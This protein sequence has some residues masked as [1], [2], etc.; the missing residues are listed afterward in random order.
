MEKDISRKDK[1]SKPRQRAE[2]ILDAAPGEAAKTHS[3]EEI[4]ALIHEMD[5]HKIELEMQNDEL[6][7]SQLELQAARDKYSELEHNV[8]E[9]TKSLLIV[10]QK[11]ENEIGERKDAEE[12]LRANEQKYR[13]LA[14]NVADNIWIV[15]ANTLEFTFCS[16]SIERILGYSDKETIAQPFYHFLGSDSTEVAMSILRDELKKEDKK[17]ISPSRARTFEIEQTHKN[18]SKVWTEITAT[19]LRDKNGKPREILGVTRDIS[20]RKKADENVRLFRNLVNQSND[21]I[22]VID[23]QTNRFLDC[24]NKACDSLGY[25]KEELLKL[26]VL[27]IETMIPDGFNWE[28]RVEELRQEKNMVFDGFHKR[29]DGTRFPVEINTKIIEEEEKEYLVAVA[30]DIEVRR[31][32]EEALR[33]RER[34]FSAVLNHTFEFIGLMSLDGILMEANKAALKFAGI[35]RSKVIGKPFW[36]APWWTH[37]QKMQEKLRDAI[38]EAAKGR[39]VRFNANHLSSAGIL[40]DFD[41]SIKPVKDEA[42][43]VS[44]LI[45]EGRDITELTQSREALRRSQDKYRDLVET[46]NDMIWEID[47]EG[48]YTY[49]SPRVK[50]ALGYEQEELLGSPFTSQLA[51]SESNR[52]A[53]FMQLAAAPKSLASIEITAAHKDGYPVILER[54]VKP[55]FGA[56]GRLLGFRGVDRDISKRKQIE[57]ALKTSEER[58]ALVLQ[59]ANDGIWDWEIK[60]EKVHTSDR[61]KELIGFSGNDSMLKIEHWTSRIHPDHYNRAMNDLKES[62]EGKISLNVDLL[63]RNKIGDYRWNNVRGMTLFDKNGR[64]CRMVGSVRDVHDRKENETRILTLTQ[65]L[66]NAQEIERQRISRELHDHVAQDLASSKMICSRLL[67]HERALTDDGRQN[68]AKISDMLGSVI[69]VV[70]DLSYDLRSP[71][72]EEW[73]LVRS[74]S[75]Y[76]E[77]FS[78]KSGL[79]IEFYPTGITNLKLT[80][81]A[82]IHVFRIIQEGLNNIWRHADAGRATIKLVWAFPNVILRME[83]DGKGFDMKRHLALGINVKRMGLHNM[84]ERA[85]LLHGKLKIQS[86]AKVGTTISIKFPY[87]AN[88]D[89]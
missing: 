55:F 21:S 36:E 52:S 46:V 35:E 16:P 60:N 29:K 74:V 57:E 47:P 39:L 53:K 65:Q 68:I 23:P 41:F 69:T 5:V 37:S 15:D 58:L 1:L 78:K 27:D 17:E 26:G 14:E 18:G 48:N 43:N 85:R 22:F 34:K 2:E 25:E 72:L 71:D 45:P 80:S 31:K 59:A 89:E 32:R 40:R 19:F 20:E 8:E 42:G 81:E 87:E 49:I 83:D 56:N 50:D 73:G 64:A 62:M 38:G 13:L 76:C 54:S 51:D 61:F 10:N 30:R 9:R 44:F 12:S 33:D 82:E 88:R 77:D 7:R 79:D 86:R 84:E 66:I 67:V 3:P 75:L 70:R 6:R 11:L 28:K 24:N 4:Q 63:V